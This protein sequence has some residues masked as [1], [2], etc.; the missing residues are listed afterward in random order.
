[1]KH[2]AVSCG[3]VC[4]DAARLPF[5]DGSFDVA[6]M[7]TVLGEVP[8]PAAAVA[9]AVRVLRPQGCLSLTE[10]AGDPDRIKP[11]ELDR[12]AGDA[13][14]TKD[15]SWPGLLAATYNYRKP[16]A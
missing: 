12:L 5:Q 16:S 15:A 4:G 8:D 10:A 3:Y 13:G 7:I 2:H 1:M 14:L 11:A 9:E 6:F